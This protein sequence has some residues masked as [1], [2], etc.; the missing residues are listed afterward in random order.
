[1]DTRKV[2]EI[3][4]EGHLGS[5]WSEWFEGVTNRHEETGQ[6][7]LYGP[8]ADEAALHGVLMRIRDLG[9][10]LAV[11]RLKEPPSGE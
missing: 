11:L 9:L 4:V 6:T 3:P 2:Y 7:V 1:M 8:I 5:G 10:L